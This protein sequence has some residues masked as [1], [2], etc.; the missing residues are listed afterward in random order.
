M[1]AFVDRE[2]SGEIANRL[3]GVGRYHASRTIVSP[4]SPGASASTRARCSPPTPT[5]RPGELALLRETVVVDLGDRHLDDLV[6]IVDPLVVT[7]LPTL[8]W[9]PHGHREAVDALLRAR[10]GVL[11]DSVE[12]PD[13]AGGA[14]TRR[15]PRLELTA[16]LR[17]RP[18][19]AALDAVARARRDD[20]RPACAAPRAA[21]AVAR[22]RSATTPTRRVAALLLSAGWPRAWAGRRARLRAPTTATALAGS[23]RAQPAGRRAAPGGRARA[24][25][26]RPRGRRRSRPRRA[27][28]CASTAAA[29]ACARARASRGERERDVDAARR[30]ARRGRHPRRGHPPGAAARPHLPRRAGAPRRRCCP[31][32]ARMTSLTTCADAEAVAERA[33][34]R[35]RGAAGR[36]RASAASRTSRSAAARRRRRTYELL[37]AELRG[38]G[39]RR[40]LVRR[41]ALRRP[42][43]RGEQLP[44]GRADAARPPRRSRPSA[45]TACEGEL[46]PDE[47]AR[48][49]ERSCASASPAQR[50]RRR[51][52]PVLDVIVLGI[53]PDGHVASLFPGAPTLDAGERRCASACTTRP[54]RRPSASR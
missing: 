13:V 53:G 35:S 15:R 43:G 23:A 11:L 36:A 37:A 41:R 44:A 4:T 34:P 7:D 32:R 31:R 51:A 42:R 29:A 21:A 20:L 19:L 28:R 48:G 22:S 14:A 47:G 5:R 54:S 3:R 17:R 45:C 16:A 27:A 6:T 2:W 40:A 18:R 38:L 33:A 52:P 24:G 50:R 1:I 12:E 46:G 26:A 8:L 39:G 49:Y 10:A 25:G 9:S 30:L